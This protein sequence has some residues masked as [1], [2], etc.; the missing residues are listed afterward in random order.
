[1]AEHSA[2]NRQVVGSNPTAPTKT[3]LD[4]FLRQYF[5]KTFPK[6]LL[7]RYARYFPSK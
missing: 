3:Q 1:M 6:D 5:S 2:F 7:D 4:V